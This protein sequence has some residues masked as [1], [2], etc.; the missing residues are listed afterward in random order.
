MEEVETIERKKIKQKIIDCL[1]KSN[2]KK[3]LELRRKVLE[4]LEKQEWAFREATM[5]KLYLFYLCVLIKKHF[6]ITISNFL[7]VMELIYREQQSKLEA[8]I[9]KKREQDMLQQEAE[10]Q[11]LEQL[12]LSLHNK[13]ENYKNSVDSKRNKGDYSF[14][15]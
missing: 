15:L 3:S 6:N 5:K 1:P 2:D 12:R 7:C 9:E 4:E 10:M 14:F 8:V 13:H 11:Q